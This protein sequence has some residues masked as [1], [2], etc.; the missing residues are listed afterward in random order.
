[1]KARYW[2]LTA[3]Y[4]AGIFALSSRS[5]VPDPG[6]SFPHL[7]KAA[8]FVVYAGLAT[9]V[10]VGR[11]RSGNSAGWRGLLFPV[12]FAL[13][14]GLTDEVHQRFVAQRTFDLLD[15]AADGAGALA[16][17][18]LLAAWWRRADARQAVSSPGGS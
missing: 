18:A 7:D 11:R 15:L 2:L 12:F 8:H 13:A 6:F 5:Q 10:S 1:M 17:S 3:L 9:V 4:C 16:A 14:Y